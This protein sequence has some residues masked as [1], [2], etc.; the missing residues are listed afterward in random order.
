MNIALAAFRK[1]FRFATETIRGP[2][3]LRSDSPSMRIRTGG[4]A[5]AEDPDANL[6][7]MVPIS[8]KP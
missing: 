6:S 5:A 8:N 1:I 4:S 3:K 7:A 2:I